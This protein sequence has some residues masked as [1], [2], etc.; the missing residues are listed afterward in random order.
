MPKKISSEELKH[1]EDDANI[2]EM[3]IKQILMNMKIKIDGFA[4]KV[5][6]NYKPNKNE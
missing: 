4:A 6:M 3:N 5:Y 1:I 2:L